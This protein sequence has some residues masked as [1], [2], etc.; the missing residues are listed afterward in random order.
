MM[1]R[2]MSS[3]LM[4]AIHVTVRKQSPY[5]LLKL[6]VGR[7]KGEG[8]KEMELIDFRSTSLQF[9]STTGFLGFRASA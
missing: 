5:V 1:A 2:H 8:F 4:P 3:I 6:L 7:N 9:F